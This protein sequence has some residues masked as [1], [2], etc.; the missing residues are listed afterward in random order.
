LAPPAA[1]RTAAYGAVCDGS[2]AEKVATTAIQ[3]KKPPSGLKEKAKD[4]FKKFWAIAIFLALMFSAFYTYRRLTLS[5][6]GITYFHYGIGI[7]EALIL[8][9]VILVG[10]AL[11]LGRRFEDEP[12]IVSVSV[13]TLLFGIFVAVFSV[14]EHVIEGLVHHETWDIIA[15]HLFTAGRDEIL[16]KTLMIMI[17]F[18]PFFAFWEIDRVLG[19]GNL[20][21]LFFRK[22]TAEVGRLTRGT[23]SK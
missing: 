18:I 19:E 22:R 17:T 8:A 3:G 12:L 10:Q 1:G 21:A 2:G 11:R 9:K 7:I 15:H 23:D 4:E 20:F 13:K 5:E 6:S 14:I 16:A